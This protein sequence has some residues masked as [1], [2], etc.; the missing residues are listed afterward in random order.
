MRVLAEASPLGPASSRGRV[1]VAIGVFDGVHRGHAT[2]VGRMVEDSRARNVPAVV[3]TFDRHP[4]LVLA[5]GRAPLM[6]YPLWRRLEA[7]EALGVETALVFTFDEAFSRQSPE[8]FLRRLL[9]G[10]GG[11]A[12]VSVGTGFV[13]GHG[14]RG[15]LA[16]LERLGAEHGFRVNGLPPVVVGSGPVSSTRLRERIAA[17]DFAETSNLLG[18]AY[19]L[20]GEVQVGDRLGRRLGFPT[21][22]LDVRGLVL[23]PEGVYAA[24]AL[25]PGL[26][27]AAAVN[28]GRRP[29]V[30]G[31]LGEVRVEAHLPGFDGDLYGCR[32]ELEFHQRLREERR[33][34]SRDALVRQVGADVA[35]VRAWAGNKGLL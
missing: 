1:A 10:F 15:D 14:R 25:G 2:V 6:V 16:L 12:S 13:F 31:A 4:G 9:D 24:V 23:P 20:A 3:V 5:P 27:R 21:A 19:S 33:F 22:N 8:V 29:T 35:E 30:T 28:I 11:L 34:G 7:L 32:L 17:G 18:R 26:R